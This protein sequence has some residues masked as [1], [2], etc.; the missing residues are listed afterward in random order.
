LNAFW[1]LRK[2]VAAF[3]IG[4]LLLALTPHGLVCAKYN[5]PRILKGKAHAMRPVVLKD[6]HDDALPVMIRLLDYDREDGD[7][8]KIKIVRQG[9]AAILGTHLIRLEYEEGLGQVAELAGGV[10]ASPPGPTPGSRENLRNGAPREMAN[11][12]RPNSA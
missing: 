9:I 7:Q 3:S 12:P 10:S 2:Y 11:R 4:L 1:L 5:V 6:I 8:Q